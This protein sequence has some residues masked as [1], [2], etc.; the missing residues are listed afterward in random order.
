M[1]GNS[2][3]PSDAKL[4][5]P[6]FGVTDSLSKVK[7][8]DFPGGPVVKNSPSSH[9]CLWWPHSCGV[10]GCVCDVCALCHSVMPSSA[11]PWTVAG[12]APLSMGILQARMLEW[13]AM[14]SSR[15]SYWPRKQIRVSSIAGRFLT[16]WAT[17]EALCG[18][19]FS[20][21]KSTCYFKKKKKKNPPSNAGDEVLIPHQGVKIPHTAGQLS[22]QATAAAATSLQLCPTLCDPIDRSP[23]GSA[24]PGTLQARILEWVAISFS[25]TCHN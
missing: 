17:M 12:K 15:G 8:L 16:S 6:N 14:P 5:A 2:I 21:N 7:M 19:S 11:T 1:L 10:W 25:T 3:N 18:V 24:I 22:L 9:S 23:P 13:V 4:W 20:L